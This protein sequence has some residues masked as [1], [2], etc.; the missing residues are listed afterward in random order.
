MDGCDTPSAAAIVVIRC[1]PRR[2][3]EPSAATAVRL[4]SRLSE[5]RRMTSET[6]SMMPLA[7][8]LRSMLYLY[9]VLM[10][11]ARPSVGDVGHSGAGCAP[12]GQSSIASGADHGTEDAILAVLPDRTDLGKPGRTQRLD[13]DVQPPGRRSVVLAILGTPPTLGCQIGKCRV[14]GHRVPPALPR[15]WFLVGL[16]DARRFAWPAA[17]IELAVQL[18]LVQRAAEPCQRRGR[19]SILGQVVTI[20]QQSAWSEHGRQFRV[21]RR[22]GLRRQPVQ[23]SGADRSVRVTVK[24]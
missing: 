10:Y 17:G 18:A 5:T 4:R 11:L 21:H 9:N 24:C 1:G 16:S 15:F 23:R 22:Q 19:S 2:S 14:M 7:G 3:R 12:A 6:S 8:W 20:Q 13:V